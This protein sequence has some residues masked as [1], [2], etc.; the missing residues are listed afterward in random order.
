[1]KRG[2]RHN[3]G[4]GT[5]LP[6]ARSSRAPLIR[7]RLVSVFAH[8]GRLPPGPQSVGGLAHAGTPLLVLFTDGLGVGFAVGIEKFLTALLPRRLEFGRCDVPVRPAFLGS[9]TKVL[10][11]FF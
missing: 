1:M 4:R 8:F 7:I 6:V 3:P 2:L 10:A 9:G 5:S 11:E